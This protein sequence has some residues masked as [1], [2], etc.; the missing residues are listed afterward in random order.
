MDDTFYKNSIPF[1]YLLFRN[2]YF[3]M[4][5]DKHLCPISFVATWYPKVY[6]YTIINIP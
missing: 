5:I 4:L 3:S 2:T 6:R 1:G